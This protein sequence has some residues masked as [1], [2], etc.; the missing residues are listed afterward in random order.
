MCDVD[1]CQSCP[2]PWSLRTLGKCQSLPPAEVRLRGK[3]QAPPSGLYADINSVS[4]KLLP[5]CQPPGY[6]Q[7]EDCSPLTVLLPSLAKP[8]SL[9]QLYPCLSRYTN[10]AFVQLQAIAPPLL[11][12]YNEHNEF[13]GCWVLR[14]LQQVPINLTPA[15]WPC[16]H[17]SVFSSFLHHLAP[18]KSESLELCKDLAVNYASE[19][20][21]A[22]KKICM[23]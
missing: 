8:V 6:L 14:F 1:M 23:C 9:I 12:I 13:P 19:T 15:F 4:R 21:T 11:T 16:V 10:P 22:P 3:W 18:I 20:E 2:G 17:L 5:Q 7:S